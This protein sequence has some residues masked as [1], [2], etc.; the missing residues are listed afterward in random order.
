MTYDF[1]EPVLSELTKITLAPLVNQTITIEGFEVSFNITNIHLK[2]AA[3][4]GSVPLIQL[5]DGAIAVE[6]SELD[7]QVVFDYEFVT[8]P[9]ILGDIG[10]MT[11]Q[12]RNLSLSTHL[13]S[14]L[15]EAKQL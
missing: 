12:L 15:N 5:E 9:P 1:L 2:E 13:T 4:N 3:F 14:T 8:N 10:E 11:I 6:I 7:L